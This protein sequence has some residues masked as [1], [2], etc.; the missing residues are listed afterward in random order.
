MEDDH[1]EKRTRASS[2]EHVGEPPMEAPTTAEDV[3]RELRRIFGR[4]AEEVG[5]QGQDHR[6]RNHGGYAEIAGKIF[7]MKNLMKLP[8]FDGEDGKWREWK[9]GIENVLSM[10]SLDRL[11]KWAEKTNS[12]DLEIEFFSEDKLEAARF[13]YGILIQVCTGKALSI[14]RLCEDKNGLLAWLKLCEEYEPRIAMRNNAML[15]SLMQPNWKEGEQNQGAI[16]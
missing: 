9:F 10:M 13:L 11:M 6:A 15:A 5:G 3:E 8:P 14:L 16:S 2:W 7:D 12:V 1:G 4:A